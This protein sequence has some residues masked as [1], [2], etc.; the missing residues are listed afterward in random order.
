MKV[1]IL[2]ENTSTNPNFK[3][4]HGLSIYLETAKHKILFDVGPNNYFIENALALGIDL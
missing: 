2:L 4:S 1:K 3:S